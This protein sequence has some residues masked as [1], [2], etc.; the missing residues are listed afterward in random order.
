MD[1][2]LQHIQPDRSP[3]GTG[4]AWIR[5][6]LDP[7]M[8]QLHHSPGLLLIGLMVV[9][10]LLGTAGCPFTIPTL[11]GVA[12][13][14]GEASA[15][16]RRKGILL[17]VSFSGGMWLGMIVLGGMAG[18][19]SAFLAGPVRGLWGLLMVG[20]AVFLGIWILRDRPSGLGTLSGQ[21]VR[22]GLPGAFFVGLL[23]SLGPPLV[24]LLFI[25]G[26]GF[27]PMTPAFGAF[28]GFSFGLGRSLP[29]LFTAL[30]VSPLSR[31][32]CRMGENRWMRYAGASALFLVA[33]YYLYLSKP[34][35]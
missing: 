24:S 26:L 35:L 4:S 18:K 34:F 8:T 33:A 20:L 29:F 17:G 16:E 30:A 14:A 12:G 2:D 27:A 10:G 13:V 19:A 9:A 23:Y 6:F 21:L 15:D 31:A 25:F 28:L 11:L 7:Y 22:K 32:S 3:D 5:S 1:H